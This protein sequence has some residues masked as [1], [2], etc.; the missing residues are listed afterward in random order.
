MRYFNF[1]ICPIHHTLNGRYSEIHH[2]LT[3][4]L[5]TYEPHRIVLVDGWDKFDL[6]R[7]IGIILLSN[8]V[9]PTRKGKLGSIEM[10]GIRREFY[11]RAMKIL[12]EEN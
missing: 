5:K 1:I 8:R 10:Y 9:H 4:L 3:S 2:A 7:K 11:N 12:I 6:N